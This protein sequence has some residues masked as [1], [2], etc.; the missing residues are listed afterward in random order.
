MFSRFSGRA[1]MQ[2]VRS[3][4]DK[5]QYVAHDVCAATRDAL[6]TGTAQSH[7][8]FGHTPA[9]LPYRL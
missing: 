9:P 4:S 2:V 1:P 8:A 6:F 7:A 5:I 3:A